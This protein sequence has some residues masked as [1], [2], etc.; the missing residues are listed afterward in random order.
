MNMG[1]LL[2]FQQALSGI[3]ANA[4]NVRLMIALKGQLK[5]EARIAKVDDALKVMQ[6]IQ[7]LPLLKESGIFGGLDEMLAGL[8]LGGLLGGQSTGGGLGGLLSSLTG[9]AGGGLSGLLSSLMGR[10]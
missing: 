7:F 9:S 3:N 8:P 2:K 6:V 10:R 4:E 1:M 5:D